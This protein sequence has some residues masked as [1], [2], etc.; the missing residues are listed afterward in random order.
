MLVIIGEKRRSPMK[1]VLFK[2]MM[3]IE[4]LIPPI[5][6]YVVSPEMECP[7]GE[8]MT[9]KILKIFLPRRT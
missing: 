1:I 8:Q 2:M 5:A 9:K 6:I 4:L 7:R 3:G